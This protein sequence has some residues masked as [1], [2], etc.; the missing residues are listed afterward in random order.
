MT[1]LRN[2]QDIAKGHFVHSQTPVL[3]RVAGPLEVV[4]CELVWDLQ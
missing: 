3:G 1:P 2:Q 4:S